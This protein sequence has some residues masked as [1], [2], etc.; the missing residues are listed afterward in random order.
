MIKQFQFSSSSV[1]WE[2]SEH[3]KVVSEY[4]TVY[5]YFKTREKEPV[6][7]GDFYGDPTCV[8]IS[9]DLKYVVM[10]GCGII[11]YK[12]KEPFDDYNYDKP[13][14]QYAEIGRNPPDIL[15]VE[16]LYQKGSED[17]NYFRF[18]VDMVDKGEEDIIFRVNS[19]TLEVERLG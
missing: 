8:L 9:D 15:W 2:E 19:E 12:L 16:A 14:D 18:I 5:L 4:E 7:I 11:I 13:S 1:F 10:A 6:V 17:C 3:Y